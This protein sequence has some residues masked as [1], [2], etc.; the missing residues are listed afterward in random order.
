MVGEAFKKWG[1]VRFYLSRNDSCTLYFLVEIL[2]AKLK[3]TSAFSNL[4][5][6][7]ANKNQKFEGFEDGVIYQNLWPIPSQV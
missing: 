6:G 4:N 1:R 3:N 2:L 5:C 7:I